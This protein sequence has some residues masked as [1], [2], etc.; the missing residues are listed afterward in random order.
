MEQR[1]T[2]RSGVQVSGNLPWWGSDNGEK[3]KDSRIV[4]WCFRHRELG[5]A[6]QNSGRPCIYTCFHCMSQIK[7]FTCLLAS[8]YGR[9][10]NRC[11]KWLLSCSTI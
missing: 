9:F 4:Q 1:R 6:S 7:R 5:T 3:Q 10:L 8:F 11:F 2:Q